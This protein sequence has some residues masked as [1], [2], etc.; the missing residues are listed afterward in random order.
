M[1]HITKVY[2]VLSVMEQMTKD[3][4][5]VPINVINLLED[6]V[7]ME[8]VKEFIMDPSTPFEFKKREAYII[9]SVMEENHEED[10]CIGS[11]DSAADGSSG[12]IAIQS[13]LDTA[14]ECV[15][16]ICGVPCVTPGGVHWRKRP[17][18]PHQK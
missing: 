16:N 4:R 17:G 14:A 10:D 8:C 2:T 11:S 13:A 5:K 6:D 18:G 1:R 3:K 12:P 15:Y 7:L 9:Q